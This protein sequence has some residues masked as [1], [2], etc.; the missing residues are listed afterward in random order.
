MNHSEQP[1]R[2]RKSMKISP[3]DTKPLLAKQDLRRLSRVIQQSVQKS[4]YINSPLKRYH[5]PDP[6]QEHYGDFSND[7]PPAPPKPQDKEYRCSLFLTKHAKKGL[8]TIETSPALDILK[9]LKHRK[10]GL[11]HHAIQLKGHS[12][13]AYELKMKEIGREMNQVESEIQE[14]QAR[15]MDERK[16][17]RRRLM[18][19][20]DLKPKD[21][22]FTRDT[23]VAM[24]SN[25]QDQHLTIADA[26]ITAERTREFIKLIVQK[27][28]QL[29]GKHTISPR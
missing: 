20:P 17:Q 5:V 2:V 24:T 18:G 29:F 9:Q 6:V 22:G 25:N 15:L 23:F 4:E 16:L 11:E 27:K 21:G 1:K 14:I 8:H 7:K 19:I 26:L 10:Q 28:E 3:L 13:K 12:G